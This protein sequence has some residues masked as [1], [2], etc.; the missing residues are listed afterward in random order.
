MT[1]AQECAILILVSKYTYYGGTMATT[2]DDTFWLLY[3]ATRPTP[4]KPPKG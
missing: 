2:P 1:R 3:R 4:P